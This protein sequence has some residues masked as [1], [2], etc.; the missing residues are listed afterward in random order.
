MSICHSANIIVVMKEGVE[1]F[2]SREA[3]IWMIGGTVRAREIHLG[4]RENG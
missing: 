1:E 3:E 4:E 2:H